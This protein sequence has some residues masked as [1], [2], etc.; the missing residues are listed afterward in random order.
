MHTRVYAHSLYAGKLKR[1]INVL[2]LGVVIFFLFL[3]V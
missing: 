3:I 2:F 1:K